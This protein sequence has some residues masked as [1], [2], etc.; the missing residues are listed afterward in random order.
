MII[1]QRLSL[2]RAA[3]PLCPKR[4]HRVENGSPERLLL[5]ESG[6]RLNP[7][8]RR[9]LSKLVTQNHGTGS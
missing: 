3:G 9:Q 6:P 7:A 8:L 5:A 2:L 4:L 1:I